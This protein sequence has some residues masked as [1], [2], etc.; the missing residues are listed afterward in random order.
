MRMVHRV[1]EYQTGLHS[2]DRTVRKGL[3]EMRQDR[4]SEEDRTVENLVLDNARLDRIGPTF[5]V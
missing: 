3:E 4:V 2:Q 1:V 5:A